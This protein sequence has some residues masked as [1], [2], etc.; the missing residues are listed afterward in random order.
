MECIGIGIS[1]LSNLCIE[2]IY[3]Y[4]LSA[5]F[6]QGDHK[7]SFSPHVDCAAPSVN[8]L[9]AESSY[10]E[11]SSCPGKSVF[12]PAHFEGDGQAVEVL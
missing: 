9:C 12:H 1:I 2:F 10:C 3:R 4:Q 11:N 7:L 6:D 5:M 8:R